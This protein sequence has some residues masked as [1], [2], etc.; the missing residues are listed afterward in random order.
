M[1]T[2]YAVNIA[3]YRLS[4]QNIG[5]DIIGDIDRY[6]TDVSLIFPISAHFFLVL[7]LTFLLIVAISVLSL[8]C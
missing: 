3:D 2:I 8:N 7:P 1:G 6:L 5:T 4:M